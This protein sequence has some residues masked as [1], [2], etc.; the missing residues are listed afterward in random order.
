M[1]MCTDSKEAV[2]SFFK[3]DTVISLKRVYMPSLIKKTGK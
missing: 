3:M 1:H 2:K